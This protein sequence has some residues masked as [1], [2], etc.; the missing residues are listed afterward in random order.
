MTQTPSRKNKFNHGNNNMTISTKGNAEKLDMGPYYESVNLSVNPKPAPLKTENSA[1][2]S[3]TSQT[4]RL[5]EQH[6]SPVNQNAIIVNSSSFPEVRE[7][8]GK[9][10][11]GSKRGS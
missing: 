5:V 9:K 11:L 4:H 2:I 8:V 1:I 7:K 10:R 6:S 3:P